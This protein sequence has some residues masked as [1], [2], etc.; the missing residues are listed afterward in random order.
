[1]LR[2]GW[3]GRQDL[4]ELPWLLVV[5][6]I[7]V[8]LSGCASHTAQIC[9]PI[10][11]A[12]SGRFLEA[13]ASLDR[14]EVADSRKDR[15]L[16]RAERAH[17]LH[18]AGDYVNSNKEFERAVAIG[19]ALAPHSVSATVADYTINEAV[20]AYPGEDHERAYLH[21]YMAL[22]YL[23][24]GNL[25]EAS[26]ECRR[27]DTVFK[28]LDQRYG[29]DDRYQEDPF[30]RF[31]SGLIYE[32][33]GDL[34]DALVDYEKAMRSYRGDGG[35]RTGVNP[36]DA[37]VQSL[38]GVS[39]K[40]GCEAD[41]LSRYNL[42]GATASD[43]ESAIVVVVETGW[44]PYKEEASVRL[45]IHRELVPESM[46]GNSDLA[47]LVKVA[48]P[49]FH[50]VRWT[51]RD[52]SVTVHSQGPPLKVLA[53]RVH[54]MGRLVRWSLDRRLAAVKTRSAMRA[55][56]KQALL[57]TQKAK[58]RESIRELET[59]IDEA[60]SDSSPLGQLSALGLKQLLKRAE[61]ALTV[62]VAETEQADTR[63]WIFL[64]SDVWLVRI[65]V[66]PG[67]H[68]IRV[69]AGVGASAP[70]GTVSLASGQTVFRCC[71][72]FGDRH[73]VRCETR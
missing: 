24:I 20:K 58:Q 34:D 60:M 67:D 43:A 17:L 21:Y 4:Q 10:S 18:L 19:D 11:Y 29:D 33:I 37:L 22:N 9:E 59:K 13:A 48:Y 32:S 14:T 51:G 46:R 38:L 12:Y 44:V 45:P 50:D 73:P 25:R 39:R 61:D 16:Y 1:M 35:R 27:L 71:R 66:E 65:P 52:P 56:V 63:N 70:L 55:T 64:P 54:D 69:D 42:R 2:A 3:R 23:M 26:V 41:I 36:P 6:A 7:G 5:L 62:L 53:E 15:F 68:E 30:I 72:I 49:K 28:K 8:F 47:A 31:L 57:A 40:L